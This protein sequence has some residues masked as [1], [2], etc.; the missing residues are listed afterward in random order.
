MRPPLGGAELHQDRA[1]GGGEARPPTPQPSSFAPMGVGMPQ[2]GFRLRAAEEGNWGETTAKAAPG[3]CAGHGAPGCGTPLTAEDG[4][5]TAVPGDAQWGWARRQQRIPAGAGSHPAA[6]VCHLAMARGWPSQTPPTSNPRSPGS[7]SPPRQWV[8]TG[9]PVEPV[10]ARTDPALGPAPSRAIYSHDLSGS[11]GRR[12][13]AHPP[14]LA[15]LPPQPPPA[16]EPPPSQ[17]FYPIRSLIRWDSVSGAAHG[18]LAKAVSRGGSAKRWSTPAGKDRRQCW[19]S[20][21]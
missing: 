18:Q 11:R 13:A 5:G 6:P 10:R 9:L 14:F 4:E 8:P 21:R 12:L 2:P 15:G 19:V 3:R 1:A 7:T 20:P 16:K 17:G